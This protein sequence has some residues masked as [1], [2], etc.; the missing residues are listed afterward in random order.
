MSKVIMNMLLK[1]NKKLGK[2]VIV[3]THDNSFIERLG[4]RVITIKNGRVA[5]DIPATAKEESDE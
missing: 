1:I 4:Q 3:V 5:S 2:T